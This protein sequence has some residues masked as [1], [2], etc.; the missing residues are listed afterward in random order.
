MKR[1]KDTKKDPMHIDFYIELFRKE[2]DFD[3]MYD[4]KDVKSRNKQLKKVR[5]GKT[6]TFE[7]LINIPDGYKYICN[8]DLETMAQL[9]VENDKISWSTST[10]DPEIEIGIGEVRNVPHCSDD[11]YLITLHHIIPKEKKKNESN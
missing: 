9:V 2:G 3:K 6:I 8:G 1:K 10:G 7:E 5:A 4:L 11:E